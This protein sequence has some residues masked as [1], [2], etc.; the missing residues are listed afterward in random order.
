V[1]RKSVL[2][3]LN[4][5]VPNHWLVLL[6]GIFWTGVGTTL[7]LR[8]FGWLEALH[9]SSA[10]ILGAS[11][12]VV[13]IVGNRFMLES[14]ARKNTGRIFR[15]PQRA[16]VFA[17]TAWKGYAMIALMITVGVA[18]RSSSMPKQYLAPLYIAMGGTLFLS[19]FVFYRS[20]WSYL[21]NH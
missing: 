11:G 19:S 18:L 21:K 3:K 5:A 4:P 2:H 7:C 8:G 1:S 10:T 12:V 20:F 6:A 17:F 16:C 14:V 9:D 15:L 13:A